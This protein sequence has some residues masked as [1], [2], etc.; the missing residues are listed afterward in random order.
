MRILKVMRIGEKVREASLTLL[1][2]ACVIVLCK[3]Y[4]TVRLPQTY[5]WDSYAGFKRFFNP[6]NKTKICV[7]CTEKLQLY[8]GLK[9][10]FFLNWVARIDQF[11]LL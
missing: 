4:G 7:S 11:V 9:N 3:I 1:H 2:G 6:T 10:Y 8:V 5:F